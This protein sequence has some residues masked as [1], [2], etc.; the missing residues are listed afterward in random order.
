MHLFLS[1]HLD[2]A[3]LSC[4]GTIAQLTAQGEAVTVLTT[5]AGDPP[6]PLPDTPIV[7]DLHERWQAGY[8]PVTVRRREDEQALG[9]L[10]AKAVHWLLGDCVYR[11]APRDGQAV[12]LYPD[13]DSLW[14]VIQADD[15]VLEALRSRPTPAATTVYAPLGSRHHVDHR[16]VRDW[17]MWLKAQNPALELVFYEEYP[18]EVD[19]I[20]ELEQAL[21]YF[22]PQKLLLDSRPIGDAAVTAKIR[23]IACYES[24]ISTFWAGLDEMEARTRGSMMAAG[25][26]VPVER[27]WQLVE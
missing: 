27:F 8:A 7:A 25:D 2:D 23:A 21:A 15:P 5:M 4:G 26:G 9:Q 10:G 24:Q 11:T 16:I 14:G 12:P 17:G 3:V 1:P 13:E 18:Y 22:S 6:D 19:A 20:M